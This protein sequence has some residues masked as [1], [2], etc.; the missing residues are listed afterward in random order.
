MSL[1]TQ[2]KGRASNQFRSHDSRPS[3]SVY[4]ASSSPF[5]IAISQHRS[6]V[7]MNASSYIFPKLLRPLQ[8]MFATPAPCPTIENTP[9]IA[10]A[11]DSRTSR[12]RKLDEYSSFDSGPVKKQAAA[13][14]ID[15]D[16]VVVLSSP[17]V[18]PEDDDDLFNLPLPDTDYGHH[19][20]RS[21]VVR[22][23]RLP[24]PLT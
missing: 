1:G 21:D 24:G 23:G 22:Y 10:H 2:P 3:R 13:A 5:S 20:W 9:P 4:I 18:E 11:C 16:E 12:K 19:L 8:A 6:Q 17:Q 15:D 14:I 7:P